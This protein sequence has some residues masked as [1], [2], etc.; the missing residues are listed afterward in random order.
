M[1]LT[2][3]KKPLDKDIKTD[4]GLEEFIAEARAMIGQKVNENDLKTYYRPKLS[5]QSVIVKRIFGKE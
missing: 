4:K 2:K 3:E 5:K 1:V